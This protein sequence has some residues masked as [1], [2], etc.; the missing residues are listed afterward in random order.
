MKGDFNDPLTSPLDFNNLN[1]RNSAFMKC[2]Q[3]GKIYKSRIMH[4]ELICR[5]CKILNS[6]KQNGT[7]KHTEETKEK[8][9]K[10]LKSAEA[11]EKRKLT[12]LQKYGVENATQNPE[13]R[14]KINKTFL[15]KFGGIFLQSEEIKNKRKNTMLQKYG[16]KSVN[17]NVISFNNEQ[18]LY[19]EKCFNS[20]EDLAYYICQNDNIL[21]DKNLCINYV[22][23]K[24]TSDYLKLFKVGLPFPYLQGDATNLGLIHHFH[25]SI[26]H[27]HKPGKPSPV[28]AWNDKRLV[29]R[30]ALNRLKYVGRCTPGDIIQGFNVAKI[31]PKVTI[32]KPNVAIN[33]ITKY[34]KDSKT[35]VD[36][37]SGFSGR[38]IG[39]IKCGKHYVGKDINETHVKE[40]N[41]ILQFKKWEKFAYVYVEDLLQKKDVE[42]FD[43]LFT[44][45]PY[46]DKEIWN[47][48]EVFKTCD[49]WIDLCLR[50][51]NCENYLFVV[52]K[53][54]KHQNEI[55]ETLHNKSHFGKNDEYVVL[56][57][58][59]T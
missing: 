38:M 18:Y 2:S 56:I 37:F 10:S 26:Y 51:Y 57:K 15:E 24:Y 19:D 59:H 31:A 14:E 43:A 47:E 5:E 3:C 42:T 40:S 7:L 23:K 44:C 13:I 41:E 4:K 25:K 55:V 58:A 22:N 39:A 16:I 35:I 8:I 48:N 49:E 1:P 46:F 36:P 28:E 53:T 30:S 32:F 50:H 20:I 12:S 17:K 45:P 21:L 52:D 33:L 9:S 29:K 11:Q 6:K 27:A 54:E 34:L